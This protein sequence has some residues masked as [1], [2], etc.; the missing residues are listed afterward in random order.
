MNGNP[1]DGRSLSKALRTGGGLYLFCRR[2]IVLTSFVGG[3][4]M[5]MVGLYQMGIL[6]KLPEPRLRRLKSSAVAAVRRPIARS[7]CRS[8]TR[9]SAFSATR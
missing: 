9:C 5:M 3:L 1:M 8:R 2:G 7:V 6:R 4:S